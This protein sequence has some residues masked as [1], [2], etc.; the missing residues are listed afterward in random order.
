MSRKML[1]II[2]AVLGVTLLVLSALADVI[3]IG[4][5]GFG[6]RQI[7]GRWLLSRSMPRQDRSFANLQD[8]YQPQV[9]GSVNFR[10]TGLA[11][12]D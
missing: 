8:A 10:H 3:G 12:D 11:V 1:G 6:F 7:A 2:V 4:G 9:S 5:G